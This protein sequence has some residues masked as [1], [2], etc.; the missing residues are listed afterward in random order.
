MFK[1]VNA[2]SRYLV[3]ILRKSMRYL[4]LSLSQAEDVRRDNSKDENPRLD[5]MHEQSWWGGQADQKQK[6]RAKNGDG[7]HGNWGYG[8]ESKQAVLPSQETYSGRIHCTFPSRC[9]G[10]ETLSRTCKPSKPLII[11]LSI[12]VILN[13][14]LL[15]VCTSLWRSLVR[16]NLPG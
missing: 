4:L 2:C 14:S 10:D 1:W 11:V 9:Y 3:K 12:T 6:Q 8:R 16:T 15:Y 13:T 7:C 5:S